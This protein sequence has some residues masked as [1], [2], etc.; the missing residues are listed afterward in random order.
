LGATNSFI[1]LFENYLLKERNYSTHT[2]Q[3]YVRDVSQYLEFSS[4][5]SIPG[6]VP[7]LRSLRKW[8]RQLIV[9]GISE[10]SVHRKVSSVRAYVKFLFLTNRISSLP[11]LEM[12]LPK[13]KKRI[14]SYV[15]ETEMSVLLERLETEVVDYNTALEFI[16]ISTFYHTG[17]RRSELIS[18]KESDFSNVKTELKVLGKGNKERI[19]PLSNEA[20]KNFNDFIRIK[21]DNNI[22]STLFFCNFRQEKLKE[23]WVYNLVNGLLAQ[24]FAD[25]KSPHILR[26]SFATHLLQNGADINAIKELLG[27]SSLS[28]TQIYAHNDI[29]QLKK[30]YKDTHPFSD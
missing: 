17:I 14:P 18:L 19:I 4:D 1:N 29:A 9:S 30:V 12:Q 8:V 2:S 11:S 6:F 13:I 21:K 22:V 20:V 3:A 25:K 16:I 10:K 27:H 24:T 7:D 28:A 26:H 15:K 5:V 23:K